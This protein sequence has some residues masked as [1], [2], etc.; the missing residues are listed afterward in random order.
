M[1][2]II[3]IMIMKRDQAWS[4]N[5]AATGDRIMVISTI[6]ALVYTRYTRV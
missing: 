1:M 3:I 2:M 4:A 5:R 6:E